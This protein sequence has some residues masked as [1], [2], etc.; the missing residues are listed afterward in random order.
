[1]RLVR[2]LRLI[3][4]QGANLSLIT[5]RVGS[6]NGAWSDGVRIVSLRGNRL[7]ISASNTFGPDHR[8]EL[9][10]NHSVHECEVESISTTY[11]LPRHKDDQSSIILT[12]NPSVVEGIN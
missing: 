10:N 1:M 7:T 8:M 5:I 3:R 4:E 12:L 6:W 2:F 9:A 11:R